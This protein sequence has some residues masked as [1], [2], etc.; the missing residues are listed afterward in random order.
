MRTTTRRGPALLGA[1]AAFGM[2]F[3]P[4]ASAEATGT[5]KARTQRMSDDP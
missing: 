5:V 3:A 4:T 2:A 1:L